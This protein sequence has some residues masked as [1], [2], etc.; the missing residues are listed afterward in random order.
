MSNKYKDRGLMKWAPF[1][2]LVPAD[3]LLD[4]IRYHSNKIDKPLLSEEIIN[5]I[6]NTL[7]KGL[8]EGIMLQ[9]VYYDNG[10][11]NEVYSSIKLIDKVNELLITTIG[12]VIKLN[13][14][15]RVTEI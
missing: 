13:D 5:D 10:Y 15:I 6:N 4:E 1:E 3:S 11:T 7:I 9:F 14:I 12:I 8:N 2:A